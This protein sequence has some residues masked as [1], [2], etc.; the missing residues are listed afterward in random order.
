[1]LRAGHLP[2]HSHLLYTEEMEDRE[3]WNFW[4]LTYLRPLRSCGPGL[5]KS[6]SLKKM[7]KTGT[8][9]HIFLNDSFT[10]ASFTHHETHPL[11]CTLVLVYSQSCATT[12]VL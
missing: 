4:T 2:N 3:P 11:K 10:E 1:M 6:A 5:P 7:L 9:L 12:T 8:A